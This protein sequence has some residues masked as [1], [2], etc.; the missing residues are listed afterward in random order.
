MLI[1]MMGDIRWL[2]VDMIQCIY[3]YIIYCIISNIYLCIPKIDHRIPY[4]Q[5]QGFWLHLRKKTA[6]WIGN[7]HRFLKIHNCKWW[8]FWTHMEPKVLHRTLFK[9]K[10]L[11]AGRVLHVWSHPCNTN[12]GELATLQTDTWRV[13]ANRVERVGEFP[14][15]LAIGV[16]KGSFLP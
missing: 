1:R 5:K 4:L 9:S 13:T 15:I 7:H 10:T 3:I 14:A 16:L 8:I 11:A 6:R 2:C 12:P